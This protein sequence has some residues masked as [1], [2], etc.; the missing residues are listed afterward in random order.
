VTKKF[1]GTGVIGYLQK[2]YDYVTLIA[3]VNKFLVGANK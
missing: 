3:N 2:P 1:D